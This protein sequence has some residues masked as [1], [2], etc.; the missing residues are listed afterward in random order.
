MG[1]HGWRP[2]AQG[3][4]RAQPECGVTAASH[5]P[6]LAGAGAVG[7]LEINIFNRTARDRKGHMQTKEGIALD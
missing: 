5:W 7:E 4:R 6:R 2:A 1:T 3:I